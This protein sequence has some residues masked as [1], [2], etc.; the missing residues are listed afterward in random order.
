MKNQ[1]S[2][3]LGSFMIFLSVTGICFAET[4][5][6]SKEDADKIVAAH[7][8]GWQDLDRGAPRSAV[9]AFE[10]IVALNPG[11]D[12]SLYLLA[13]AQTISGQSPAAMESLSKLRSMK[14]C[15]VPRPSTFDELNE[16]PSY[17]EIVKE[18]KS[19]A[20]ALRSSEAAFSVAEKDLIPE[21]I[22]FDPAEKA[23]YVSSLYKRKIVRI[24]ASGKVMDFTTPGQDGL[25]SVL[26]MKVDA[27]RNHLWVVSSAEPEMKG[28][29]KKEGNLA[30]L[31]QYDLK[32]KKLIKKI[33]TDA[34]S[35]HLLNDLS[36]DSGGTVY[37][38]DTD[39][40][41][42]FR[43][44][45]DSDK[46]EV[47][48]PKGTFVNPNGIDISTDGKQLFVADAVQGIYKIDT[49]TRAVQF[50]L[51]PKGIPTAGL[52]GMYFYDQS[53]IG[54]SNVVSHGRVLR[55]RLNPAMDQITA[56]EVL[57]CNHPSFK[58]PT[59]G[60]IVKDE[61]Y[62]IANSQNKS[63]DHFG[64]LHPMDQLQEVNLL[65]IKLRP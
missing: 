18:I 14:S 49:Q 26:G 50:L 5:M 37:V 30:A 48:A 33:A 2:T 32:T 29:H 42:I 23:F 20:E 46:L 28:Y 3:A 55:F 64:A 41:E 65:K 25:Y 38:T 21:G 58:Y 60:V 43:I 59:N 1:F 61:L 24:D 13:A 16:M 44:A 52:D 22:A 7:R 56:T 4:K 51:Y 57:E 27:G 6:I 40:G 15:L 10:S 47:F 34:S 45:K 36:I 53:L 11:D 54:I 12:Y 35:S 19:N 8:K 63:Y 62:Y 39:T 9:K 17:D 31:F